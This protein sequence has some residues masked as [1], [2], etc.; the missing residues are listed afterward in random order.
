MTNWKPFAQR[1]VAGLNIQPGELIQARDYI[2]RPEVR[3]D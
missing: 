1:I 3:W 2:D